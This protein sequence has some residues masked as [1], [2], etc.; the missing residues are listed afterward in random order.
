M[1]AYV[2]EVIICDEKEG[3]EKPSGELVVSYID[4]LHID[5]FVDDNPRVMGSNEYLK[6]LYNDDEKT[7]I[8]GVRALAPPN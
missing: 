8:H 5:H 2:Y 6:P 7:I 1:N 3:T 4:N